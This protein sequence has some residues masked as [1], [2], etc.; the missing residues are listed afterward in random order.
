MHDFLE[1]LGWRGNSGN[2]EDYDMTTGVVDEDA[3]IAY[4]QM[5]AGGSDEYGTCKWFF[6][7]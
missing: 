1:V 2:F 7:T 3:V 6:F 4:A 5:G